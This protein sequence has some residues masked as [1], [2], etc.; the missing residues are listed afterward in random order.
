MKFVKQKFNEDIKRELLSALSIN[1]VVSLGK[2]SYENNGSEVKGILKHGFLEAGESYYDEF[3]NINIQAEDAYKFVDKNPFLIVEIF[4]GLMIQSWFEFLSGI[5]R[6]MVWQ[7][8]NGEK[9]YP[10]VM[11]QN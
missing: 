6:E 8:R 3:T 1:Y 9:I 5:Y 7:I 2:N 4:H 10:I 11:M